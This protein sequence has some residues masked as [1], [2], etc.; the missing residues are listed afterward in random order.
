MYEKCISCERLGKDCFPN[1]CVMEMEDIRTWAKLRLKY[2]GWTYA[3]LSEAS[4]V[5]KGTI[6]YSFSQKGVDVN[7][8]TFAP[9]LCALIDCPPGEYPCPEPSVDVSLLQEKYS[10]LEQ[11]NGELKLRANEAEGT[12]RED[13]RTTKAEKQ[14]TIGALKQ[15]LKF[16]QEQILH[17]DRVIKQCKTKQAWTF[18]F[19]FI[20]FLLYLLLFDLPYPDAG[21][22]RSEAVHEIVEIIRN[23]LSTGSTINA[24]LLTIIQWII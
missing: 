2:K 9:V 12:H 5:P 24:A 7:Y 17:K 14:K 13:I 3:D 22:I 16:C 10:Q 1:L 8:S 20:G 19:S 23:A 4:G 6:A 21:L 11:E 15:D 18:W